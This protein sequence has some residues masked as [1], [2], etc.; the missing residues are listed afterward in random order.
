[1]KYFSNVKFDKVIHDGKYKTKMQHTMLP[2]VFCFHSLEAYVNTKVSH[3]LGINPTET[4]VRP[5]YYHWKTVAFMN[6]KWDALYYSLFWT[7]NPGYSIGCFKVGDHPADVERLVILFDQRSKEPMWVYF[8]AHGKGEGVW[9]KYSECRFDKEGR[10]KVY[11]SPYSHGLYPAPGIYYRIFGL[12]ND[13]C[14]ESGE[15]WVPM[16]DDFQHSLKQSWSHT[17]YQV[18]RGINSPL[19]VPDPTERSISTME[20][21]LIGVPLIKKRVTSS[22]K[23]PTENLR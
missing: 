17:H 9:K 16:L 18:A 5:L 2:V 15:K 6:K 11:V 21:F 12:A 3:F 14:D 22:E 23:L 4:S 1:M 8:G 7:V 10:L 20:R 19:N 13:V